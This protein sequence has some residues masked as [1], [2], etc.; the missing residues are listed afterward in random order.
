MTSTLSTYNEAV[1]Q[2]E[3]TAGEVTQGVH[4]GLEGPGGA[5]HG[6]AWGPSGLGCLPTI[7]TIS[8]SSSPSLSCCDDQCNYVTVR[9]VTSRGVPPL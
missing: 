4:A 9:Y 7:L 1:N 2:R 3:A 6:S 8:G 5:T